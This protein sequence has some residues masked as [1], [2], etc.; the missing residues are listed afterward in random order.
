MR[1]YALITSKLNDLI[2]GVPLSFASDVYI[3]SRLIVINMATTW[4]VLGKMTR[5]P[6]PPKWIRV[7]YWVTLKRIIDAQ[8]Q[9]YTYKWMSP[10]NLSKRKTTINMSKCRFSNMRCKPRRSINMA[11][12]QFKMLYLSR[13]VTEW[14]KDKTIPES[15]WRHQ[16]GTFSAL[17]APCAGNS[18]ATGEF[19]TQR[20]ATRSFDGFFKL[21]LIK[22][23]SKQWWGWWFE[24]PSRLFGRHGNVRS[25][26]C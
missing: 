14:Y 24:T 10:T 25:K 23:L 4:H 12:L 15:W 8:L 17:L 5:N 26:N 1:P 13:W 11:N 20:P 7:R 16:M 6:R 18:P 3:P 19:P 9:L 2:W 22:R 21:H